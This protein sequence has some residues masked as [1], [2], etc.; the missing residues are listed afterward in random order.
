[1]KVSRALLLLLSGSSAHA[2]T[3]PD[4]KSKP[5]RLNVGWSIDAPTSTGPYEPIDD[6]TTSSVP[7]LTTSLLKSIVG[8]GVLALPASIAAM[9]GD[10]R[11]A[12]LVIGG[13][14]AMNAYSFSLLG[15][16]CEATASSSYQQAW[17]RTMGEEQAPVVGAVVTLKTALACLAYAMIL[18]DSLPSLAGAAG[19]SVGRDEALL[20]VTLTALLPLTL[21]RDLSSLAPFSMAGLLGMLVTG[22]VIL[23][24]AVDGSYAGMATPVLQHG[25][26]LCLA[27]T[28]STAFVAHY[29]APRL[30]NE[31]A[32]SSRFDAVVGTAY[33]TAAVFSAVIGVA[34][35]LT[36]G[37]D[38]SGLILNNYAPTD[39]AIQVAKLALAGSMI[40]TFPLPFVGL[41]D[42]CLDLLGIENRS[43]PTMVASTVVLL[44]LI[45]TAAAN[46]H[47]L[48]LVLSVGGGTFAT[49]VAS[50]F[51]T[52]M[53]R[54]LPQGKS[55]EGWMAMAGMALSVGIGL[56][57]VTMALEKALA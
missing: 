37:G 48:S 5:T 36:F 15:R 32:D 53:F 39:T 25:P 49:A 2:W 38:V 33:T 42:G 41:R 34:G 14:A 18:A 19:F 9:G 20:A 3:I 7:V 45:T 27:C 24:H 54:A 16:V 55:T 46:L 11:Q 28:S 22:G 31:L 23:S 13:V 56:T 10:I 17:E 21:Q 8:G 40:V 51:P 12:L 44:A 57:G 6:S 1:M 30:Y 26:G 43:D 50:V 35:F 29:N 52:L 47:D 4:P